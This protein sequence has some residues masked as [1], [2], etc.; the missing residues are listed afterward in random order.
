[1]KASFSRRKSV[2]QA[3]QQGSLVDPAPSAR[4]RKGRSGL[5]GDQDPSLIGLA[6][7]IPAI[8][9]CY[10]LESMAQL[11][12]KIATS[13][14]L[15]RAEER[16]HASD[17]SMVV[18]LDPTGR[19]VLP[20]KLRERIGAEE[21]V[22]FRARLTRS[23]S[24]RRRPSRCC[25]PSSPRAWCRATRRA[26][27]MPRWARSR[28]GTTNDVRRRPSRAGADRRDSGAGG[29]G[30]R[31]GSTGPSGWRLR[32]GADRGGAERVIGIDRD[33]E[34][35]AASGSPI[36]GADRAA[37]RAFQ[38]ARPDRRLGRV[39]GLDRGRARYRRLLDA[40]RPGGAGLLV[41]EGRP[42]RHA[43][44]AGGP[45]RPPIW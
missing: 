42:A 27:P 9:E 3:G 11:E 44:G 15:G 21:E 23:A 7:P 26:T 36:S 33:P 45:L 32:A 5:R 41:P 43:D 31:T 28:M 22:L 2:H 6:T 35:L 10:S 24:P 18:E 1:M 30:A 34:A 37:C 40:A 16:D 19:I 20:Q 12:R 13:A 4:A 38:R 39:A 25:R 17:Q 29:A 8:L 14:I